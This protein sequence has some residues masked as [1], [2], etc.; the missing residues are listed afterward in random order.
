MLPLFTSPVLQ[1]EF[2]KNGFVHVP[3]LSEEQV[4][5]L[6]EAYK[7]ME[8]EHKAIGI[9]FITSSH[10]N[11]YQLIQ[12]VDEAI[13]AVFK[14]EMDKLLQN[15]NLLFGNFLIKQ[16][17]PESKTPLHQDTSFVD[18]TKYAS[19]SVWVALTD[20]TPENGCM[21]FVKGSHKFRHTIRPSHNYPW[22]YE[23]VLDTLETMLVDYP[24]KKGEAFIFHHGLIHASY[25]NATSTPRVAAILAAYPTNADLLMYFQQPDYPEMMQHYAM[26]KDAF[27]HFI[28]GAPPHLGS[29]IC[30]E[31]TNYFKVTEKELKQITHHP[32]SFIK[33]LT[34][35][36]QHI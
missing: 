8:A 18:E 7:S 2:D 31:K 5:T 19:I 30:T 26:T 34:A 4:D 23:D 13:T 12:R 21:R 33:K 17:S 22:Y 29:L 16:P 25:A 32:N 28:K 35:F 1:E 27:L 20:T 15:Y 3:F 10:S 11:D 14:P 24:S 9:P 6:M 36:F